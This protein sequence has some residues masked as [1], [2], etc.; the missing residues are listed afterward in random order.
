MTERDAKEPPFALK[1]LVIAD[2]V[3][4]GHHKLFKERD[5]TIENPGSTPR[6]VVLGVRQSD[7]VP[8]M[9]PWDLDTPAMETIGSEPTGKL[10]RFEVEVAPHSTQVFKVMESHYHPVKTPI[11]QLTIENIAGIIHESGNNPDVIAKLQPIADAK[12]KIA[13]LDAQMKE[14]QK[15][16]DEVNAEESRLRQNI[17]TLKGSSEEKALSKRYA[18]EMLAQEDKL[19]ALQTQREQARQQKATTQ[20]TLNDQIHALQTDIV[21]P[22]A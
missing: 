2:G 21:F 14:Q 16:I 19:S 9:G 17:A 10:Y 20:K 7:N 3:L 4:T 12:K 15:G 5:F 8:Q 11:E 1:H 6:T 22:N 18:D 13:D